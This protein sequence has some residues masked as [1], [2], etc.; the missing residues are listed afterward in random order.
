MILF[1]DFDGVLHPEP[2]IEHGQFIHLRKFERWLRTHAEI[3]VVISSSWRNQ[4][5]WL[6]IL[7]RFSADIQTRIVGRTPSRLQIV[8]SLVPTEVLI[9]K[10]EAEIFEWR[11]M[12]GRLSDAWIAVDDIPSWFSPGCA[13]LMLIDPATGITEGDLAALSK[14]VDDIIE[15]RKT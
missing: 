9:Y 4:V 2:C 13:N 3:E 7:D 10:R 6:E 1:L 11:R 8:R 5:P 12:Q 15:G 14:R